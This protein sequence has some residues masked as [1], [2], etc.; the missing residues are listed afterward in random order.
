[1]EA[2]SAPEIVLEAKGISK[3]FGSV[4]ALDCVSLSFRKGEIHTLL[5]ENGAGKTTLM[6][7]I[8][9]LYQKDAGEILVNGKVHEIRS[10]RDSL[11]LGIGMVP[12]FFK[13]VPDL[14]ILENIYLFME[15]TKFIIDRKG[16]KA[17][18]QQLSE[19]FGFGLEDK[20]DREVGSLTEGEKQKVEILKILARGSK[21]LLFDEA[22]NVLAPNEL[23]SFLQIVKDLNKS[24]YSIIYITHRLQ[25]ALQISDRISAFRKGK[26]V[27]TISGKEATLE[28]LTVMM[29][30]AELEKISTVL[31][32]EKGRM[33]LEVK[34]LNVI[35]ERGLLALKN[36][37]CQF[38]EGEI[39]G[40]AGIEGNGSN[41]LAEALIGLRR[42]KSGKV[43]YRGADI[44]RSLPLHRMN[45]GMSLM[46]SSNALVPLFSVR[47]NSILDYPEKPPFS[48]HGLLDRKAITAHAKRIVTDYQVQTPSILLQAVKLSGGNRQR[49]AIG[50]KIESNPKF[51][52][53]YHPTKGLDI[54]SQ[55][56][57]YEKLL[58]M[59]KAGM[60]VLFM[61]ADLDELLLV[62]NRL[63]V[64]YRG[65][66]VGVFD[67]LRS[68]SK[69]DVGVLMTGGSR[70]EG[71]AKVG[72]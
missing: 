30:G 9:G 37:S 45:L 64:I 43:I 36:V 12:Q 31:P 17:I 5:G 15:K 61:G 53:A 47:D 11:Q 6:N 28:K 46:P 59:K 33:I 58:T 23:D 41:Y 18:I 2:T 27:G 42:V 71:G 62:S 60:T 67:D 10:P 20:I 35:D 70:R 54:K 49:L 21:I 32:Q 56:F 38:Y 4:Q 25:E 7:I 24:G 48:R 1:M 50:R 13:L 16:A 55:S 22:T 51:M 63:M 40:L 65:E 66:I 52:I 68:V 3:H 34:D 26:L 44:T 19:M 57:I 14:S 72:N 39:V 29:V 8:Y 69:F